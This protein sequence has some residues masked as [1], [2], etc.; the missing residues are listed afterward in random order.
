MLGNG[1][2]GEGLC[3]IPLLSVPTTTGG[4]PDGVS[5]AESLMGYEAVQLFVDRARLRLPDFG[6]T[7]ENAGAVARVCRKVDGIPLAIVLQL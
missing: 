2:E 1:V 5:A 4:E 3:Q 6:L 7:Q